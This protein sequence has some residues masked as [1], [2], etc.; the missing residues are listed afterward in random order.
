M[1]YTRGILKTGGI[2][3]LVRG[4]AARGAIGDFGDL[5]LGE[6]GASREVRGQSASLA[7]DALIKFTTTY[8]DD[9][10]SPG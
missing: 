8:H 4:L 10:R 2:S 9:V 3:A 5:G 7:R 6:W 1:E